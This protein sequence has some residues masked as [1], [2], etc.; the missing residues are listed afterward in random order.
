MDNSELETRAR[1]TSLLAGKRLL[2]AEEALK[3]VVGHFFEYD[4]SVRLICAEYRVKTV[5]A[6]HANVE[7][8]VRR[9]IGAR[10]A[11]ARTCWE[12]GFGEMSM[13]RRLFE[14]ARHNLLVFR[15]MRRIVN[16]DGPF[17][18]VIAP[19]VTIYHIVGFA[20]LAALTPGR[21]MP[22]LVLF[23][24]N[25]IGVYRRDGTVAI[26]AVKGRIWRL[27]MLA[28]SQ[29]VASGRIVLATDSVRLARE[30]TQIAGKTPEVF[31]QPGLIVRGIRP[32]PGSE[33][34][35]IFGCLG[36]ARI[37]KGIDL[38]VT[39]IPR[40]LAARPDA[41]V[42][43]VIQWN[44]AVMLDDGTQL[45]PDAVGRSDKRITIL[46]QAMDSA[47]YEAQLAAIDC[48][49]LPYRHAAYAARISG[50]AVEAATSGQPIITT[51]D[52]WSAD[53]VRGSGAG[54]LVRDCDAGDL[55][56]AMIDVF[57]NR[58]AYTANARN[59]AAVSK[60]VHSNEAFVQK[61]W[62]I[63]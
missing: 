37:E 34:P 36:P 16:Q 57:D 59:R 24:R 33:A 35:F 51:E 30:Y 42:R 43:F 52:T 40:F 17:D 25:S 19:T 61:L 49:V 47:S 22:R 46:D 20:L 27:A 48:M 18:C 7:P 26:D 2:I 29:P 62:G 38:L 63:T 3:S 6:A 58:A 1:L 8:E 39:A 44:C 56:R 41:N 45:D 14:I 54:V 31:P 53:L 32:Q 55:V 23:F 60:Q 12:I 21:T 15:T 11:F 10:P 13:L 50:V 4:R 9:A 5:V 28:V